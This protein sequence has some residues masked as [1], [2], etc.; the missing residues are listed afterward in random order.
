MTPIPKPF[1]FL[2]PKQVNHFPFK[3]SLNSPKCAAYPAAN[4]YEF[5]IHSPEN[6]FS[7]QLSTLSSILAEK[8][9][10]PVVYHQ[11]YLNQTV[12]STNNDE[13]HPSS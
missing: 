10:V 11:V 4:V 6:P 12:G 8:H 7:L 13:F 9:S 2:F 1:R 5:P 3:Y